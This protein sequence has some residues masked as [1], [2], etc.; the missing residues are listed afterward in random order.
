LKA[1]EILYQK[2]VEENF[3]IISLTEFKDDIQMWSHYSNSH[4][5]FCIGFKSEKLFFNQYDRFGIGGK[6]CYVKDMPIILPTEDPI[7]QFTKI[8]YTKFE[9][10]R[11]EQ[12][13]R[14]TKFNA[15]D[16]VVHFHPDE[17]SEIII[18]YSA[19][20]SD[21]QSIISICKCNFPGTPVFKTKQKRL[22]F[23]LVFE[24]I[25]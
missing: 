21:T 6:V 5:G 4:K 1:Q 24:Q 3:G 18:G 14:L 25:L 17:V 7:E 12:E 8:L 22:D 9:K 23:K 13:Y 15:A 16:K 2:S 11:Y 19:N 20:D 10:W